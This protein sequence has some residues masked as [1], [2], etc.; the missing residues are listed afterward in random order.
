ML[1]HIV[2]DIHVAFPDADLVYA[3]AK[4]LLALKRF[5]GVTAATAPHATPRLPLTKMSL[6][7]PASLD[8]SYSTTIALHIL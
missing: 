6:M 5:N 3:T 2:L 7:L 4:S 1:D 8:R